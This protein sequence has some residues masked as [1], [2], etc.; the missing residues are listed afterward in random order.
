MV[1]QTAQMQ[2]LVRNAHDFGIR[3]RFWNTPSSVSMWNTFWAAGS[4]WV[5]AD[6]LLAVSNAWGVF[7]STVGPALKALEAEG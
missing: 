4:D 1:F 3:T 2:E 6:D 5:N 7:D